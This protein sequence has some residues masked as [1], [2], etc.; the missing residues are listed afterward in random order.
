M[1]LKT[2]AFTNSYKKG[3]SNVLISRVIIT[4]AFIPK[5]SKKI[6]PEK[7]HHKEYLAIWDTGATNAAISKK[8]IRECNLKPIGLTRVQH[9]QGINIAN[10]YLVN[11]WLPNK[12]VVYNVRATEAITGKKTDILIGMDIINLGDFAITNKNGKTV[13]T[14]RFPSVERIDFVKNPHKEKPLKV[15]K[16]GRNE[17]C[18]CGSG[19]KY[20]KCCGK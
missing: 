7:V 3:I 9:A 17:P 19:K 18:P 12:V 5:K 4:K 11:L 20:K 14:Y 16:V 2:R 6:S 10:T 13:F 15:S 8:V 1:A